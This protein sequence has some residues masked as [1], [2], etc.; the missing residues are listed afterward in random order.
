MRYCLMPAAYVPAHRPLTWN[1]D[2]IAGVAASGLRLHMLNTRSRLEPP[3][4]IFV[5]ERDPTLDSVERCINDVHDWSIPR[6]P[7]PHAPVV[8]IHNRPKAQGIEQNEQRWVEGEPHYDSRNR[9]QPTSGF[10]IVRHDLRTKQLTDGGPPLM[11]RRA[12]AW[13]PFGAAPVES[14]ISH[15]HGEEQPRDKC[16]NAQTDTLLL[17]ERTILLGESTHDQRLYSK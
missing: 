13:P 3:I 15:N 11:L 12:T 9:L 5:V 10:G 8:I 7:T 2:A 16:S 4:Y 1:R 14:V 6:S 17:F